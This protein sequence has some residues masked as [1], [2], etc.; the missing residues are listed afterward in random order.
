MTTAA[1]AQAPSRPL[2]RGPAGTAATNAALVAAAVVLAAGVGAAAAVSPRL[3][4]LG[5]VALAL[6]AWIC[7]RPAVAG[8]L[9]VGVTPLIV[10]IDRGRVLPAL[11]PNEALL[12]IAGGALVVRGVVTRR[13]GQA[14][15][16]RIDAL[17]VTIAVMATCNSLFV[18]LWMAVR[19]RAMSHDDWLYATVL[20]KYF[21]LYLIVRSAVRTQAQ[22]RR[23][24]W[25]ALAAGVVVA[26]VAVL[27]SLKLLG[28]PHLLATYY[29][30]FGNTSALEIRRGSSLLSLP[31][32][33]AD[34]LLLDLALVAGA[35]SR[36]IIARRRVLL[37]LCAVF[38]LGTVASGQFSALIGLVV[39]IGALAL[40]YRRKD[41]PIAGAGVGLVSVALMWPVI[42][43]RLAG[44]QSSAGMPE[45]WVG[46]LHNLRTYFWP[47]VFSHGNFVFGVRPAARVPG[48]RN[49]GIDWVWIE[50]GYTWL[51]WGGGIP[52][53]CA[54]LAF[55]WV[56]GRQ[57]W[58]LARA[59]VD[60]SGAAATAVLVG[61]AV[62]AVLM[63]FDPH[64]TYR[65]SADQLFALLALMAVPARPRTAGGEP[66]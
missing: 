30:P 15:L 57:A 56:A 54:F 33:T 22:V 55:T 39:A 6:G 48:P 7:L 21:A 47:E 28:V 41:I 64:I 4:L 25:L 31:A 35:W 52:L 34:L 8:Y 40:L 53:L 20:W 26:V 63:L 38:V 13:R 43:K 2:R 17:P 3:A 14:L 10:G 62:I 58:R 46:R 50:S 19:G 37:G 59:H 24:L 45:S 51:L 18:I 49:L 1:T 16:G 44:F 61:I 23:C 66:R 36:R 60:A 5:A 27:Q 29:A 42:A 9:L 65:G 12:L 32:A 11:R